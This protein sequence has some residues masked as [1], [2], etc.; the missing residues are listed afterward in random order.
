MSQ[1]LTQTLKRISAVL[2]Q[3]SVS[4]DTFEFV[5]DEFKALLDFDRGY[6]LFLNGDNFVLKAFRSYTE[7]TENNDFAIKLGLQL[8]S[9]INNRCTTFKSVNNRCESIVSELKLKAEPPYSYIATPLVIRSTLFGLILL[10]KNETD[11]YKEE[12][13][14]IAESFGSVLSYAVKDSELNNIFKLQLNVLKENILE[15]SKAY[16]IIKAQNEKILEADRLKSEF[17]ANIS[18]ELRT[19]LNAIIGFSEALKMKIFGVLNE[20]QQ[21]YIEDIYVSGVH[22][23]GMIN[24]LLD[25]SKIEANA[26]KLYKT[27]FI[28]Y[29]AIN[30]T[31][32]ITRA[33]AD[34]K[35]ISVENTCID[36]DLKLNADKQK[37]QQIMYNLL[38]NAVKFTDENG[39]IEVG[40][41]HIKN[42]VQ[43]YVK[44]NGIGIDPKYHGKIFAKFQQVDNSYTRKQSSTGLGLTITKELVELHDGKIWIQSEVNKGTTFTFELPLKQDGNTQ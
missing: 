20:K 19:P 35:N 33:L 38:S 26:M 36:K 3:V 17:L 14:T 41:N 39:K 18:H 27:D 22:L 6:I 9:L 4:D 10:I 37:F 5:F 43:V 25:I 29:E 34:K 15:K 8:K 12:D 44:D 32:N 28:I 31:I 40:I 1:K 24:D 2:N 11:F 7:N 21:E 42:K 13:A 16:E 23:L 30:E